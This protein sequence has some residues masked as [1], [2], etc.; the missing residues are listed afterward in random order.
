M[1]SDSVYGPWPRRR[2]LMSRPGG[3]LDDQVGY[4]RR[5]VR[6]MRWGQSV[7]AVPDS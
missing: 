7:K 4:P 2:Q 3:L 5:G 1:G 6:T